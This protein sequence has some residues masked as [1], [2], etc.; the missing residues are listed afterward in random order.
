VRKA[1][2]YLCKQVGDRQAAEKLGSWPDIQPICHS[3]SINPNQNLAE[4]Q[5]C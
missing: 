5:S 3:V 1:D 4:F 2:F